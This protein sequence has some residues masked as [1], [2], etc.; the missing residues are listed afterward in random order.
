[1]RIG[2]IGTAWPAHRYPQ[3][4]ITE[5][6]QERVQDRLEIFGVVNRLDSTCDR[7][8]RHIRFPLEPWERSP[9]ATRAS[10]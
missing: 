10:V 7:H 2:S 3:A 6:P 8:K 4:V 1:M 5:A 9:I